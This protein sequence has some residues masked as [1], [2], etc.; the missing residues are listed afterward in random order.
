MPRRLKLR[1]IR[2]SKWK[3]QEELS[4]ETGISISNI[5]R[6]ERGQ[7]VPRISTVRK[8]A[9]AL[10]VEP[11]ALIDWGATEGAAEKGK[12]GPRAA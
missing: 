1:E 2:E 11:D 7:Q 12:A 4:A 3:T 10:G 5:S 6:I 8:L 9:A